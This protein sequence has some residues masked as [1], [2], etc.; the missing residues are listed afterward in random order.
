MRIPFRKLTRMIS[1][2]GGSQLE[3]ALPTPIAGASS[4]NMC[5]RLG[6]HVT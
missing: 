5:V 1:L 2:L 3:Q 4:K 6:G